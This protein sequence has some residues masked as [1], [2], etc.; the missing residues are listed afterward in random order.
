MN[1]KYVINIGR[2]LGSGGRE[3]GAKL[4]AQLDISFYD[5]E[6]INIA[7]QESGLCK[8]FFEKADEKASRSTIGLFGMRFPFINDGTIPNNNCL[9]NDALFKIQSDAIRKLAE[10]ESCLFVGRCADYI[11][12]DN[13][14]CVNIFISASKEDRIKRLCLKMGID[15]EKAE[16]LMDKTDRERASYYNYY[17]Y[18]IWGAASTYHLC[19][20][21][22]ALGID[23]TVEFIKLFI[24]KKLGL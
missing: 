16:G 15:A 12:R 3:I 2:Q 10:E 11:L 14:H 7:S 8:E 9:S 13:P 1:N 18:K 22:S 24:R 5:K 19:I 20:D 6:L 23:E 21:S 17:S 4:A